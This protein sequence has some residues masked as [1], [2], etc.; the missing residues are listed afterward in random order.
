MGASPSAT[1]GRAPS[2]PDQLLIPSPA[3]LALVLDAHQRSAVQ[4]P[5]LLLID[6]RTDGASAG[7]KASS[8]AAATAS[9][10][11]PHVVVNAAAVCC[12]AKFLS[13]AGKE[14]GA[15]AHPHHIQEGRRGRRTY[16][17]PA[18]G[19]NVAAAAR[20]RHFFVGLS[21]PRRR[22]CCRACWVGRPTRHDVASGG[23]ARIN[24]GLFRRRRGGRHTYAVLFAARWQAQRRAA[25]AAEA[26]SMCGSSSHSSLLALPPPRL[27]NS[28]S[29]LNVAGWARET[30]ISTPGSSASAAASSSF[31]S[32]SAVVIRRP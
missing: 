27:N 16:P 2:T 30:S 10:S 24:T 13:S 25:A 5:P 21:F 17:H 11:T 31:S 6:P 26:R 1:V 14:S 9:P 32:R 12:G 22:C 28:F 18:L 3:H 23:L 15:H 29:F 4:P 7:D 20:G 19:D 8:A